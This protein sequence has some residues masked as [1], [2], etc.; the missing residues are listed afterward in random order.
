MLDALGKYALKLVRPGQVLGLGTGHAASSFI[1]ALGASGISVRG[2]ATSN[3][4]AE[5]AREAGV[6]VIALGDVR[7]IDVD[8][9][10]ADEVDTRLNMI[11]GYG[12]ALVREKIVAASSRRFAVL[13]GEEKIVSRLG[14]RGNLPVEVVPFA[15]PL[16]TRKI[17][18]LGLKPHRREVNGK[19]FVTDNGN[20]ILDCG[21][22]A[23][24][25][26]TKLEH[27][28]LAIPGV[29]GTG[30]FLAMATMVLVAC[31]DGS[32]R[33]MRPRR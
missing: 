23:L 29:V 20:I 33:T 30:F 8:F 4:S 17:M 7:A 28:L 9:D 14:H 5:L 32:I 3:A 19:P 2:V 10:G 26:P 21:A 22:K 15:E 25:S 1:R 27:E 13:V 31:A 18:A 24:A 12:G 16:V 6:E 11:K